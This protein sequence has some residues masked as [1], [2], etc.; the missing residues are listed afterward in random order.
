[1]NFGRIRSRSRG[2][3]FGQGEGDA[4]SFPA[5]EM[6]RTRVARRIAR[7]SPDRTGAGPEPARSAAARPAP[8][9]RFLLLPILRSSPERQTSK[10]G[11]FLAALDDKETVT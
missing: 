11:G 2:A 1:M 8:V 4:A 6:E 9:Y 3:L 7:R 5:R 10:R